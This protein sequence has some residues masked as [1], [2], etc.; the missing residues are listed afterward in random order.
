MGPLSCEATVPPLRSL[1]NVGRSVRP[2]GLAVTALLL[3]AGASACRGEPERPV[4]PYTHEATGMLFPAKLLD[5]D[6]G[7]VNQYADDGS[8]VS[9][10]YDDPGPLSLFYATVYVYPVKDGATFE[11]EFDRCAADV[12][13]GH[14]GTKYD[15]VGPFDLVFGGQPVHGRKAKFSIPVSETLGLSNDSYLLLVR[16]GSWWLKIRTTYPHQHPPSIDD[17]VNALLSMVFDQLPQ[18][19][20]MPPG[21]EPRSGGAGSP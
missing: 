13:K 6:L 14:P 2:R 19:V 11:T 18:L 15:G 7:K 9:V 21:P 5:L 10:H 20:A 12:V 1:A 3:A 17:R 4:S 8:D 16:R